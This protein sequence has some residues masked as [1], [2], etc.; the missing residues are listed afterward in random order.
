MPIPRSFSR[1]RLSG[2]SPPRSTC[3]VSIRRACRGNLVMREPH[4]FAR[5]LDPRAFVPL[6][7][8]TPALVLAFDFGER[9]IGV[10]IGNTL[11]R[12]A[13]PL[14]T[15]AAAGDARWRAVSTLVAQWQPAQLVVGVARYP[16]G[17]PNPMTARCEKL[18]RRF[19]G[20]LC[21]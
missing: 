1:H 13:R 8:M 16:D 2:V 21:L 6:P 12:E 4:G 18:A 14:A 15:L 20:R 3:S 17:R 7:L 9:R 5:A 10:A 19:R 11:T